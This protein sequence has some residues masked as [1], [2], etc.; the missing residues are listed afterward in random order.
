MSYLS[1]DSQRQ[2]HPQRRHHH[3]Q[4]QQQ[5][6][7][8]V[9]LRIRSNVLKTE[10]SAAAAARPSLSLFLPTSL[11]PLHTSLF[12]PA[13]RPPL[14]ADATEECL[15]SVPHF[16][17]GVLIQLAWDQ[18]GVLARVGGHTQCTPRATAPA[19]VGASEAAPAGWS[20]VSRPTLCTSAERDWVVQVC[21][22]LVL[23]LSRG[24]CR[25]T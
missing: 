22:R 17:V 10:L 15:E 21:E 13:I 20:A 7:D 16:V 18:H 3:H 23:R 19:R 2:R 5:Q 1:L 6:P 9:L 24:R 4:Q 11:P 8:A 12:R 25:R 14:K